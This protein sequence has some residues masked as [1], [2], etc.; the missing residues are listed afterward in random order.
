MLDLGYEPGIDLALL[1]ESG[2]I[3]AAY[4]ENACEYAFRA[5]RSSALLELQ[6]RIVPRFY[7]VDFD[8]AKLLA[9]ADE[10]I[11]GGRP[12]RTLRGED[13]LLVLSGVQPRYR[14]MSPPSAQRICPV[15]AAP[16]SDAK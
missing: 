14:R 4:I 13:L 7:S 15:I 6:W 16:P 3:E 8:L 2:S 12:M 5:A 9:R 1:A 10:I 11:V